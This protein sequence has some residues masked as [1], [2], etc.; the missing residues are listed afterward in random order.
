VGSRPRLYIH[1]PDEIGATGRPTD[2]DTVDLEGG[3]GRKE[4]GQQ[5]ADFDARKPRLDFDALADFA[6]EKP[7][8]VGL[9]AGRCARRG[10][11]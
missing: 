11:H 10:N 7:L 8:D 1:R 3:F 6:R 4:L 2:D 5:T 9:E